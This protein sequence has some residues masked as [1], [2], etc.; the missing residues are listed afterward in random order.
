LKSDLR[1]RVDLSI[2]NNQTIMR[3]LVEDTNTPIAGQQVITLKNSA[4]YVVSDQV[5][6]R[7][8]FDR[9]INKPL[10]SL[11]FPTANTSFGFSVRF[12]MAQ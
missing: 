2:R 3:K 7:L 1:L 10:V 8:F 4:D 9:V 11:T 6:I 12:T 5:T